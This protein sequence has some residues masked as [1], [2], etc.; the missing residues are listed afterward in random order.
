VHTCTLQKSSRQS[1]LE[2]SSDLCEQRLG[3]VPVRTR[4][5][6]DVCEAG[7][8]QLIGVFVC[9]EEQQRLGFLNRLRFLQD[10]SQF[11]G[12]GLRLTVW[13][14]FSQSSLRNTTNIKHCHDKCSLNRKQ[15]QKLWSGKTT[16][17]TRC[18]I[19][20]LAF[21]RLIWLFVHTINHKEVAVQSVL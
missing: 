16:Q 21:V 20:S 1:P 4:C 6:A 5:S 12:S 8:E 7:V 10:F 19:P 3:E 15:E 9:L 11:L 18:H 13:Y 2:I 17:D 14:D